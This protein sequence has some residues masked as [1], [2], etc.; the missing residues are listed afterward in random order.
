M[1][2]IILNEQVVQICHPPPTMRISQLYDEIYKKFPLLKNF[3]FHLYFYENVLEKDETLGENGILMDGNKEVIADGI[4]DY[5]FSSKPIVKMMKVNGEW[6][7]NVELV[8]NLGLE[9]IMAK[10]IEKYGEKTNKTMTA[11]IIEFL[12]TKFPGKQNEYKL[13]YMKGE[14]YLQK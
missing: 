8:K 1:L 11:T 5:M 3:D 6:E 14:R 2:N 10:Y 4:P 12:R 9:T 13:I 7:Y